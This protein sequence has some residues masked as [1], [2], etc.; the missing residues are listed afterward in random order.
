MK[1]YVRS[2]LSLV[3]ICAVVALM[4]ACVHG[5]TKDIIKENEEEAVNRSLQLALPEGEDFEKQDLTGLSLPST[6]TDVYR[7]SEGGYVFRVTVVGYSPGMVI[8]CGISEDGV[9]QNALCLSSNETLGYE[10]TYGASLKGVTDATVGS[11]DAISGATK[12]TV[13]YRNAVK[14][15]LSAHKIIQ[16]KGGETQ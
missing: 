3:C 7:G 4:L 1:K 5:L 6:V 2:V 14:D 15:A 12:T 8:L 13:A 9:V 11:V 16:Q 10:K